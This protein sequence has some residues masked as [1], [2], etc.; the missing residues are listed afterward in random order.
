M[1]E[2]ERDGEIA[3]GVE[4]DGR[5]RERERRIQIYKS[6]NQKLRVPSHVTGMSSIATLIRD[7]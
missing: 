1:I 6:T 5:K 4:R 3:Y 7:R 2:I